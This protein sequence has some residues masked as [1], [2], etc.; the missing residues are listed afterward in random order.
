MI[1]WE[2]KIIK[3]AQ[4]LVC[5]N[6][7]ACFNQYS[8]PATDFFSIS[9]LPSSIQPPR[10]RPSFAV[11]SQPPPPPPPVTVAQAEHKFD[12]DRR[13][14]S[15]NRHHDDRTARSPCIWAIAHG[16]FLIE[17]KPYIR[18]FTSSLHYLCTSNLS[19]D[20]ILSTFFR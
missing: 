10:F 18:D 12:D 17:S 1:N 6:S 8:L 4:N 2:T 9:S 16:I 3:K 7:H 20:F 5:F 13:R 14:S 19:V 15:K 11:A